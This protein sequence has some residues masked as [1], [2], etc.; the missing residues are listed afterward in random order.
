M[1]GQAKKELKKHA[2][3]HSRHS[4]WRFCHR[5]VVAVP[6]GFVQAVFV[7]DG[8]GEPV[9]TSGLAPRQYRQCRHPD[10][11]PSSSSVKTTTDTIGSATV[12]EDS[13]NPDT[14]AGKKPFKLVLLI[15]TKLKKRD[16]YASMPRRRCQPAAKMSPSFE[17]NPS[18]LIHGDM[19]ATI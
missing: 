10:N 15:Q 4:L 6:Q 12:V 17:L 8:Q 5:F 1:S 18:I 9:P 14:L 7:L 2:E 11:I 3:R 19:C 13:E 16:F